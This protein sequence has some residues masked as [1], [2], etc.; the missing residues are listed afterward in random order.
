MPSLLISVSVLGACT[1]VTREA[2]KATWSGGAAKQAGVVAR[3]R[4]AGRALPVEGAS[5]ATGEAGSGGRLDLHR[6]SRSIEGIGE[7]E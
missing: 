6:L 1:G 4:R 7:H 3:W 5:P 2:A